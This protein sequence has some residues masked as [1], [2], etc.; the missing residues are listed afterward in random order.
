[1]NMYQVIKYNDRALRAT[2]KPVGQW[3]VSQ[4]F[5]KRSKLFLEYSYWK[6]SNHGRYL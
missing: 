5:I 3:I 6:G 1:M 2:V 4:V